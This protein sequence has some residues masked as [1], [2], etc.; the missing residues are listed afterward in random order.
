MVSLGLAEIPLT[1]RPSNLFLQ[2]RLMSWTIM[3][4]ASAAPE[5]SSVSTQA[6]R[7]SFESVPAAL[8]YQILQPFFVFLSYSIS[9]IKEKSTMCA[10][11]SD[12]VQLLLCKRPTCAL[13]SLSPLFLFCC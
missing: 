9:P 11:R 13:I 12:G 1:V 6:P 3:R 8:R 4:E 10:Y 7:L 5:R 2:T